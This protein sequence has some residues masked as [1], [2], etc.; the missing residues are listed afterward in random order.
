MAIDTRDIIRQHYSSS[1]VDY[2]S[3]RIEDPRGRL[4]SEHDI[5]LFE[6]MFVPSRQDLTVL[7]VGAGTGRFT[8]PVLQRGCR[9]VATDIN[10]TMLDQL[11][12]K[13]NDLG[14]ADRCELRIEDI[15]KL[16]FPDNHFDYAL[17][18][19]VIPR[20]LT[21][22]DQRAAITE[23][24]RTLRPGGTFLFNYRNAK[25]PYGLIYKGHAATP[26][27]IEQILHDA[28]MRISQKRGK[29]LLNRRIINTLPIPVSRAVACLDH[30]LNGFW[31]ERAWD[32]FVIAVKD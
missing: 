19:H 12:L 7:E 9:V 27:Q 6:S 20:F 18:L 5:R 22:T 25:S 31:V 21:I 24:A 3:V 1:G 29:W 11:R 26:A 16:S 14:L 4:L 32:V 15:F 17:S 2:D 8:I 30:A 23:V 13:I 28:G 10:Q